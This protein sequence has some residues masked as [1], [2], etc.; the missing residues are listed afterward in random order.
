[1]ESED[2]RLSKI[3]G[4]RDMRIAALV[5]TLSMAL[6]LVVAALIVVFGHI[7]LN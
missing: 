7:K 4:R 6:S 5:I 1:M 3:Q 2:E